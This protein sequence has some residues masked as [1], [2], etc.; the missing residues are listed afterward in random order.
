MTINEQMKEVLENSD[1]AKH[2]EHGVIEL[3]LLPHKDIL[4]REDF[5]KQ[6]KA[7]TNRNINQVLAQIHS[8]YL[9]EF[10]K[11]LPE[12][13]PVI[14]SLIDERIA[15]IKGYNVCLAKIKTK[16]KDMGKE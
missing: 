5:Y 7:E 15:W 16:L 11:T 3:I 13:Y 6:V 12:E 1:L 10:E 2:A 4:K 14:K 8:L 9:A